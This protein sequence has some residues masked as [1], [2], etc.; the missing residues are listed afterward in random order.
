MSTT[1]SPI[2]TEIAELERLTTMRNGDR[3]PLTF[4][5]AE[6]QRRLNG[7]RTVMM[8]N[9]LDAIVLTSS[10]NIKYFSDF[11]YTQFG[12]QYALVVTPN[13]SVT[14]TP[15]VDAAMP[16][17]T[18]YGDN[19]TYTDWRHDNFHYAVQKVLEDRKISPERLG[20]E[21]DALN[22]VQF[23]ELDAWFKKAELVDIS[24]PVMQL[25]LHKSDEEISLIRDGA[26]IAD[27]GGRAMKEAI[28]EGVSEYEVAMAG[29][30]AMTHEIARAY[31]TQE[32][33]DTWAWLQSGVNTDG[34]HNWSTTRKIER[35]DLLSLNCFPIVSGYYTALE[36]TLFFGE[37]S[38][39]TLELWNFN[40]SVYRR[41]LELIRPGVPVKD[42][43][44]ELNQ[45]FNEKGMLTSL[46]FG[47]GHSFG[48]LN[49]YYGREAD[50]E[51]R[52][53][54]DTILEPGMVISMEPMVSVPHGEEGAGGYREHDILVVT[55]DGAENLTGFEIGPEH[56]IIDA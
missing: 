7:L 36:R 48:V 32:I 9:S 37:P 41:G 15:K 19:V 51:L 42:I 12:R 49:H 25:R 16:W 52:E 53:D 56:N 38:K 54:K 13:D 22:V 14:V 44:A 31:P 6:F 47:Y 39:R 28:R 40:V 29:T 3:Q 4:S 34:A 2:P 21:L 5:D 17:R 24:I 27:I 45:M 50:L 43:A 33:R 35:G 26:R 30:E 23:R 20:V 18:S 11:L 1:I 10:H 55:E 8:E 46:S